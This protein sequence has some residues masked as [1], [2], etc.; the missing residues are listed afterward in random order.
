MSSYLTTVHGSSDTVVDFKAHKT[1]VDFVCWQETS[2]EMVE[3]FRRNKTHL[4]YESGFFIKNRRTWCVP[5]TSGQMVI[6]RQ[7]S[8]AFLNKT[9]EL[10]I[11]RRD[12][13]MKPFPTIWTKFICGLFSCLVDGYRW[14]SNERPWRKGWTFPEIC[15]YVNKLHLKN[16]D[17]NIMVTGSDSTSRRIICRFKGSS[18]ATIRCL[19][20]LWDFSHTRRGR[21]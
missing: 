14:R 8:E 1:F 5:K 17:R 19:F 11:N 10:P 13:Q 21:Y 2:R 20:Y 7:K 6:L 16:H 3:W 9:L 18:G 15:V 12:L 4:I